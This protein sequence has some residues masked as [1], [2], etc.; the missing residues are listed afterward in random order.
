EA[1]R[2]IDDRE[3]LLPWHDKGKKLVKVGVSFDAKKRNIGE[4]KILFEAER[5]PT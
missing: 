4:W 3:Y 2:Q 1:L 5:N